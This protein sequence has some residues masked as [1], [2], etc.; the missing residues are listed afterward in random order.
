MQITEKNNS[1]K[2]VE[3]FHFVAHLD[4]QIQCMLK[5]ILD[6]PNKATQNYSDLTVR[7][8]LAEEQAPF[9]TINDVYPFYVK[10]SPS[11]PYDHPYLAGK[12]CR[13]GHVFVLLFWLIDLFVY[14][15]VCLLICSFTHFWFLSVEYQYHM[16]IVWIYVISC[17]CPSNQLSCMAKTAMLDITC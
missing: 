16:S 5:L 3:N 14:L 8:W 7:N 9:L 11:T 2:D 15:P 12:T 13:I 6:G 17:G 10:L 1:S 4:V